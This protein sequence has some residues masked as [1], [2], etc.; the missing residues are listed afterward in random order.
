[1]ICRLTTKLGVSLAFLG[2]QYLLTTNE[3]IL[4]G[5]PL[6]D[7]LHVF[8]I[9]SGEQWGKFKLQ[10][11]KLHAKNLRM[12]SPACW[13]TFVII[14]VLIAFCILVFDHIGNE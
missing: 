6:G 12:T 10:W 11:I 13:C 2:K 4:K 7:F 3:E 5:R 9:V 8:D 14:L 1:M